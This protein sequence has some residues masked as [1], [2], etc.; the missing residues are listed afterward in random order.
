MVVCSFYGMVDVSD[1]RFA[2]STRMG[3]SG[4]L[5]KR[6]G[7][8]PRL[9]AKNKSGLFPKFHCFTIPVLPPLYTVASY[10]DNQ[11]GR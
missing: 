5:C 3:V 2:Y 6:R 9:G 7:N 4:R 11:S 8:A 10:I 1:A